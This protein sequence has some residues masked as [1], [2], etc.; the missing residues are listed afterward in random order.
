MGGAVRSLT[1]KSVPLRARG[2]GVALQKLDYVFD[3]SLIRVQKRTARAAGPKVVYAK[4]RVHLAVPLAPDPVEK[5][6]VHVRHD[7]V[8]GLVAEVAYSEAVD[9]EGADR[10]SVLSRALQAMQIK[11]L[12]PSIETH[13]RFVEV[14]LLI[15]EAKQRTAETIKGAP[16]LAHIAN[17]CHVGVEQQC[18]WHAPREHP[19]H[20]DFVKVLRTGP[21]RRRGEVRVEAPREG[22]E[23]NVVHSQSPQIV[24]PPRG[25]SLQQGVKLHRRPRRATHQPGGLPHGL[26]VG[27]WS[28]VEENNTHRVLVVDDLRWRGVLVHTRG[29]HAHRH[30]RSWLSRTS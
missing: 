3:G 20:E 25:A 2:V 6:G 18:L 22:R 15:S 7:G 1:Y 5:V 9:V 26:D 16:K 21:V 29:W 17:R 12:H 19:R 10:V 27:G 14:V 8:E 11:K 24:N 4:V 23:H 13:Q 30:R 28:I